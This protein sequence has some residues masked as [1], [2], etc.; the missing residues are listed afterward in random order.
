MASITS[1]RLSANTRRPL[2]TSPPTA[3]RAYSI[4]AT[5][6]DTSSNSSGLPIENWRRPTETRATARSGA[7]TL[8]ETVMV[9]MRVLILGCA[10]ACASD[11]ANEVLERADGATRQKGDYQVKPEPWRSELIA[12]SN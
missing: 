1:R 7:V 4:A 5:W 6:G 10:C 2:T 3:P 9:S 8:K 12:G 11:L